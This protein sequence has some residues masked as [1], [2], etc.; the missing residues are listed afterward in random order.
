[1]NL[2]D[3]KKAIQDNL[4]EQR[5]HGNSKSDPENGDGNYMILGMCIGMCLGIVIGPFIFDEMAKGLATG[6]GVGMCLGLAI[7]S[8]IEKKK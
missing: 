7:G 6:L 5:R 2:K 8:S 4:E 3:N 1:M